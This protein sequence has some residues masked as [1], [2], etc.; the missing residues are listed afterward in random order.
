MRLAGLFTG[1]SHLGVPVCR[2]FVWGGL[3]LLC[4][5]RWVWTRDSEH[6]HP[7]ACLARLGACNIQL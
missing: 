2:G 1:Y 6:E 5:L 4:L 7:T 3:G